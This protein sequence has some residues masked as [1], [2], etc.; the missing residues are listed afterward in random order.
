MKKTLKNDWTRKKHRI[1]QTITRQDSRKYFIK[2][3][4]YAEKSIII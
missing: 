1:Y 2:E 3:S 4:K